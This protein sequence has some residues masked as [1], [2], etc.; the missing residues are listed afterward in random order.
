[1][2]VIEIRRAKSEYQKVHDYFEWKIDSTIE[3]SSSVIRHISLSFINARQK[4]LPRPEQLLDNIRNNLGRSDQ[5]II[6][7]IDSRGSNESNSE[8][9]SKASEAADFNHSC[10][11]LFHDFEL[12]LSDSDSSS[13]IEILCCNRNVKRKINSELKTIEQSKFLLRCSAT[14]PRKNPLTSYFN[15]TLK[16]ISPS[17]NKK[18]V[19][20]AAKKHEKLAWKC[21]R[22][23]SV[24]LT[25]Y[26][27]KSHHNCLKIIIIKKNENNL[28]AAYEND[29]LHSDIPYS[30]NKDESGES[31]LK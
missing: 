31:T 26:G 13:S 22:I 5:D 10:I 15:S 18:D 8:I 19:L 23:S 6:I 17:S 14:D 12:E 28:W 16:K 29:E 3:R 25:Y 11:N 7:L 9:V 30:P 27:C 20:N 21:T 2:R 24:K 4:T 1:M